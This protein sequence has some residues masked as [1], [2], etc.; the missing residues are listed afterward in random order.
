VSVPRGPAHGRA[1]SG[2]QERRLPAPQQVRPMR[3]AER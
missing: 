1:W 2:R 3:E